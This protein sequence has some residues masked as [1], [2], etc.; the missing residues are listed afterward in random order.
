M[1]S[2]EI[3]QI[4]DSL[5]EAYNRAAKSGGV[6]SYSLNSG[7]GSSSVHQASLSELRNEIQHYE[8]LYN[9]TLAAENGDN[10]TI[11]R[12]FGL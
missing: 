6:T 9:E 10:F 5:K 7:Q 11:I 3:K 8:A 2:T 1:E 4:L 12:G